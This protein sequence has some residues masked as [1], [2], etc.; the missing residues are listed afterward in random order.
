MLTGAGVYA[1][2]VGGTSRNVLEGMGVVLTTQ[3]MSQMINDQG[4]FP[5]KALGREY[6]GS[7]NLW[8]KRLML[9]ASLEIARDWGI[10]SRGHC[11]TAFTH[12]THSYLLAVWRTP[13][14]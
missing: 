1:G 11:W 8:L 12:S 5:A 7:L 3:P 13:L 14:D 4:F 6:K 2:S 10:F 9:H